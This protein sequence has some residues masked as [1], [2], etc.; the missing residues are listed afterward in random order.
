MNR[1]GDIRRWQ[2]TRT[3]LG[4]GAKNHEYSRLEDGVR[5]FEEVQ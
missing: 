5:H 1:V 2:N 4:V 3:E